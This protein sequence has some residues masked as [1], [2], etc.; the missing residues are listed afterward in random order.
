MNPRSA[1]ASIIMAV[2]IAAMAGCD[3]VQT[4]TALTLEPAS[5]PPLANA[6]AAT[7]T[8]TPATDMMQPPA[9][10]WRDALL[11]EAVETQR[12]IE[13]AYIPQR[14]LIDLTV[15]LANPG[16]PIPLVVRDA[17]WKFKIG[18]RHMFWV[19]NRDTDEY[20]RVAAR[21]VHETPHTYLFVEEGINPDEGKLK[22]LAERFERQIYPANR[23]FFGEEW[24]PG[25]DNDPHL[26]VL[27]THHVG[28]L[29]GGYQ[30]SLDEYSQ[31]VHRFSNEMEMVYVSGDGVHWADSSLACLL[32][33]EFQHVIQWSVDQDEQTWLNEAF[34]LLACPLNGLDEPAYESV[35][36]AFAQQPD[37]QLNSWTSEPSQALAQYG[38]SYLFVT[39]FLDR[40]GEQAMRALVAEQENGVDS[41]DAVLGSL[42][43]GLGIDEVFADWVVAN[44]MNEPGRADGQY[45]YLDLHL[46]SFHAEAEYEAQDLPVERQMNVRQYAA[47]YILL[48]GEGSFQVDFAGAA[49]VGLAPTLA[50]SGRFVWWGGRGTNS[51]T[52]LTREFDLTQLSEATLTFY[53][54]Y[55]IERGSD[56]AYVE[57]SADGE[58]WETLPGQTTTDHDPN[59]VIY[60]HGY[61]D[62]SHGWVQERIDLT[63]YVGQKVQ[64]RFE[65][66][67]DDGPVHAGILLD[68]IEIPQLGYCDDVE[69]SEG[70]WVARG[71]IR[72]AIA[73]PQQWLLQMVTQRHDQRTVER[74]ELGPDHTGRWE[75]HLGPDETAVLVISG[76]TRMT[77]EPAEYGYAIAA[78]DE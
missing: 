73:M 3:R 20:S 15:R 33:H 19:E 27:F 66:V 29:V 25:V 70:G 50:H 35:L 8:P 68:D 58:R 46:P 23:K 51:D 42:K 2:A 55:D 1:L 10:L 18:D 77:T 26:I 75:V 67:T 34:S 76:R 13:S 63:P 74:L 16:Q 5:T 36:D 62:A 17:P 71:F 40:F 31:L 30:S 78:V 52:T 44:Y 48:R 45:G 6:P 56:Y 11:P 37:T 28:Q 14:D 61:T 64:V 4:P 49:L 53:T 57:V 69:A 21:L 72:N 60:G 39:Y 41:V 38:A 9:G 22:H 32:A 59:G 54:W 43:A 47:D 65:Y 24:S 7:A 12:L